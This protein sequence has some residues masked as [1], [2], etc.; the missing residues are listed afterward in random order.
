ME[1]DSI[2]VTFTAQ[3]E[4]NETLVEINII[5]YEPTEGIIVDGAH[6][7]GTY[8]SVFSFGSDALKY[9]EGDE[10]KTAGS[11]D[12]LPDPTTVDLY[13]WK[14]PQALQKVFSYKVEL[15]YLFTEESNSGG[16]GNGGSNSRAGAETDPPPQPVEKKLTKVYTKTVVG[17]WSKW[18]NQLRAYVY[19]RD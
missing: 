11:W 12:A 9:R 5:N 14:A 4:T 1:G 7:Y 15:T 2:D 3:L 16:T 8:E 10:F 6:L 13:L 19:A 18:A 17:N